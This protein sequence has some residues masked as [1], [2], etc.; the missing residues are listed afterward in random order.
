MQI[1]SEIAEIVAT[2]IDRGIGTVVFRQV[3]LEKRSQSMVGS[4]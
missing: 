2:A 1:I 3:T 4:M